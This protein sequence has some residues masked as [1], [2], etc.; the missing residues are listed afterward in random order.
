MAQLP[1]PDI[2]GAFTSVDNVGGTVTW[3]SQTN[4]ED[5]DQ[6][7]VR[8]ARIL[9]STSSIPPNRTTLINLAER[10]LS[11]WDSFISNGLTYQYRDDVITSGFDNIPPSYTDRTITFF[12]DNL[13]GYNVWAVS[14]L[15]V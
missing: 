13:S 10:T 15:E 8:Y 7:R 9:T 11:S 14:R 2:Q 6:V 4:L 3:D 1:T 12:E 5:L